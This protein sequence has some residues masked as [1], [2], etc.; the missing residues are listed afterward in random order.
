M[1]IYLVA[2]VWVLMAFVAALISVRLG[3]SVALVEILVAAIAGN[4]PGLAE[5]IHQAGF[6]TFLASVGSLMLTFL[7]GAEIDPVS[8]RNHWRASVTIGFVS[9]LLPFAAATAFCYF[10]LG[11]NLRASEVG[12]IS[13]STTSVAVVYAV[14]V[15]TGLNREELGKLIL[16][17]CFVTDLGTVLALGGLF[18]EA[19]VILIVFVIVSG[20]A[21]AVLPAATR[22]IIRSMGHRV[23]E[24]EI[25]FLLVVLLWLGALATAAGSE[26]VLPAYLAGLVIAGIFVHD[27]VLI[28]RMRSIAFALLT[29]FFFLRAGLLISFPAVTAGAGVVLLLLVVKVCAKAGGV[30]PTAKFFGIPRRER[31]YL[32]LLMA[33][34]LTFGSIA[35]LFGLTHGLIDK[36]Q[37][38]QLVTVVI[39]SALIPTIIAQQ[40]FL[41]RPIVEK[42][43]QEEALGAED[44]SPDRRWWLFKRG[45]NAE[46]Q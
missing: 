35:A 26:A 33:T 29:P 23:S 2:G 44:I 13:L 31:S 27:R 14:M 28:D 32:T 24:P 22:L 4:T 8:L 41:P 15:E 17:A 46:G 30:W 37:Y 42:A 11:W 40:F 7:A 36:E 25:K 34:G 38:S 1:N 18:A 45:N 20:L 12:G 21:L 43:A 19:K 10:V 6:T 16:A 39:L 9:F 5:H 3:I